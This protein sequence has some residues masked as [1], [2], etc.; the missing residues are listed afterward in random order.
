[1][2]T[3][4]SLTEF[5]GVDFA[6]IAHSNF[7][8]SVLPFSRPETL[9]LS[10]LISSYPSCNFLR[11]HW[12]DYAGVV[13]VSISLISH[14]VNLINTDKAIQTG[15]HGVNLLVSGDLPTYLL[16]YLFDK[17]ELH[18]DWNSLSICEYAEGNTMVM[19][20]LNETH[21][22]VPQIYHGL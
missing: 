12:V 1:M 4:P 16:P 15:I 19:C 7:L 13:C 21:S 18:P 3:I 6:L 17:S 22:A 20:Y 10:R 9:S 14:T 11:Y 8:R 5:T 2:F